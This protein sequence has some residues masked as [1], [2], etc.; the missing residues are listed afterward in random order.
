MAKSSILKPNRAFSHLPIH[1]SYTF[2]STTCCWFIRYNSNNGYYVYDATCFSSLLASP[3]I[4]MVRIYL[5]FNNVKYFF[6]LC[7]K[8][9]MTKFVMKVWKYVTVARFRLF[10]LVLYWP[11]RVYNVIDRI[12]DLVIGLA[13]EAVNI[14]I[15]LIIGAIH[16]ANTFYSI[17]NFTE[18]H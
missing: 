18:I 14:N 8:L 17:C 7:L 4:L 16:N 2:V 13:R 12:C 3:L 11:I 6:L 9:I 1:V 15:D 10:R 5:L